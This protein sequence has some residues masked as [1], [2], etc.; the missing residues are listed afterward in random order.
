MKISSALP[1]RL[2]VVSWP[3]LRMKM[4]F[5]SSSGFGEL[6]ALVLAANQPRQQILLGIARMDAAIRDQTF[7]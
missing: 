5:C 2:V 7:R 1:I 4:Q 3:A 6:A